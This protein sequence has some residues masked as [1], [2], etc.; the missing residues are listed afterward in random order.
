[1]ELLSY[2]PHLA[3]KILIFLKNLWVPAIGYIFC[4]CTEHTIMQQTYRLTC[5]TGMCHFFQNFRKQFGIEKGLMPSPWQRR[6]NNYQSVVSRDFRLPQW[7]KW[8]FLSPVM[9]GTVDRWLFTDVP[10]QPIGPIF[11][12]V[13]QQAVIMN[14]VQFKSS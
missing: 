1:M 2:S 7:C 5:K 3:P 12:G 8:E 4:L 11:Q 9:L 10:G 13:R 14:A 6:N